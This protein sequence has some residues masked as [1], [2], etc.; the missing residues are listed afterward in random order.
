MAEGWERRADSA[1]VVCIIGDM[2]EGECILS[3]I[4]SMDKPR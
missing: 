4:V 2:V 3:F 1:V